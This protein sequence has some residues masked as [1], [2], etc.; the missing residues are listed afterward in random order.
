MRWRWANSVRAY[1]GK[2]NLQKMAAWALDHGY[3]IGSV[4]DLISKESRIRQHQ[5][6]EKSSGGQDL[7]DHYAAYEREQD[8]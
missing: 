3:T 1:N 6:N 5:Q 4:K 2:A 7:E 8:R